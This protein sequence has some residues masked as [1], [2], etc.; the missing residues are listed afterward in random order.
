M[1]TATLAEPTVTEVMRGDRLHRPVADRTVA[2]GLRAE[3]EDQLFR[4][5]GTQ[6]RDVITVRASDLRHNS[7]VSSLAS[8]PFG[9]LRGVLVGQLVRLLSVGHQFDDPYLDSVT[10]WLASGETGAL[11]DAFAQLDNEERA[12]L[13]TDVTA[14]AVTL[15]RRLGPI[16]PQ[17]RPRSA[18]RTLARL[19]AG[20]VLVRDQLD[21]VVGSTLTEHA[22]VALFDVTTSPFGPDHERV[23][24]FHALAHTLS[25]SVAPLRVVSLSSATD[26]LWALEV[27]DALL[28]RAVEELVDV[29]TVKV[30][31]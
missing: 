21:L 25:C 23:L 4:V 18:V 30:T 14:H 29:V 26:E 27:D 6:P 1:T 9:R 11:A 15:S 12:R 19:V 17:W 31:P 7:H 28:R 16:N 20:T 3:L 13:A 10:A 22:S 5:L 2:A 8:A 24:R